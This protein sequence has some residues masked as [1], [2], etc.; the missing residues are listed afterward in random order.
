MILSEVKCIQDQ[1][2]QQAQQNNCAL[3]FAKLERDNRNY[4]NRNVLGGAW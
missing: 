4:G 3:F 2:L 1:L